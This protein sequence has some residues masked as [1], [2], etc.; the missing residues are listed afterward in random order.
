MATETRCGG[1]ERQKL[2]WRDEKKGPFTWSALTSDRGGECLTKAF[3]QEEG[4]GLSK[5]VGGV[6][7][8]QVDHGAD[9][10][11]DRYTFIYMIIETQNREKKNKVFTNTLNCQ[12]S[13]SSPFLFFFASCC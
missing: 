8:T 13:S 2:R 7:M 9:A 12:P 1:Q 4:R 3:V 10:D 11:F 6:A 5:A